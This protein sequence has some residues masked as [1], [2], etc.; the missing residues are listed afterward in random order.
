[1]AYIPRKIWLALDP[2]PRAS[3]LLYNKTLFS[4]I[5]SD[6]Q[7]CSCFFVFNERMIYRFHS[8][9]QSRAA[10]AVSPGASA[11]SLKE[12]IQLRGSP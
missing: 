11:T 12:H 8:N 4:A 7:G 10:G 9:E 5:E 6:L 1:M 2:H 3:K